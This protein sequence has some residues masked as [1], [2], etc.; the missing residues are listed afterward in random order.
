[1]ERYLGHVVQLPAVVETTGTIVMAT[2]GTR[3]AP[4]GERVSGGGYR[5]KVPLLDG[6]GRARARR[7]GHAPRLPRRRGIPLGLEAPQLTPVLP[8]VGLARGWAYAANA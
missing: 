4:L 2:R 1:M 7:V 3:A 8:G 5:D 6:P